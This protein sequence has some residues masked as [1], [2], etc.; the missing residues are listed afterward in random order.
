MPAH[1]PVEDGRERPYVAGI[2]AFL[3]ARAVKRGVDGRDE[4]GHDSK[5]CDA[6]RAGA[7]PQK[8]QYAPDFSPYF[9][10]TDR[11]LWRMAQRVGFDGAA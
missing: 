10:Y 1:Q 8:R 3:A 9:A 11:M 6:L 7:K 5:Y 4:P 2:H